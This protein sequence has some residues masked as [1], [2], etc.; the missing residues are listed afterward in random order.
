MTENQKN[1]PKHQNHVQMISG[2]ALIAL[3]LIGTIF[4]KSVKTKLLRGSIFILSM[5]SCLAGTYLLYLGA[6]ER[7]IGV[8]G[9]YQ[10]DGPS[11]Q[12]STYPGPNFFEASILQLTKQDGVLRRLHYECP[13]SSKSFTV[14]LTRI[15]IFG[16]PK[17]SVIC[18]D[19]F[20]LLDYDPS[21]N[22]VMEVR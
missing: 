17:K 12:S 11:Q 2:I 19:G 18:D 7:A 22:F 4:G 16:I 10:S 1:A 20:R 8:I 14:Y 5:I 21:K 13:D 15:G 6:D 3:G 9:Q